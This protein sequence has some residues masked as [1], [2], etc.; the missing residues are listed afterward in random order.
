[1]SIL[2]KL[3]ACFCGREVSFEDCCGPLLAGQTIAQTAEQ[4]MRSR[5]SAFCTGNAD[6][7]ITSHHSSKRSA[8]DKQELED[9]FKQSEWLQLTII[10]SNMGL[11]SDSHGEVEFVAIYRQNEEVSRLH[12]RSQ[13]VKENGL[14]FYVD[15]VLNALPDTRLPKRNEPCW[16]G[17]GRKFKRCH[18]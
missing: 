2:K 12:E 9:S 16:C 11:A 13:F 6:Y 18:G 4:L 1:L 17:S 14:W 7:L 8:N 15:G 3:V 5:F 10:E